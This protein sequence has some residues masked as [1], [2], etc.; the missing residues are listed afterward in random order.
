MSPDIQ[1][2]AAEGLQ[3]QLAEALAHHQAGRLHQAETLYRQ[4]LASA[5]DHLEA[6]YLLAILAQQ[7]GQPAAALDLLD[8]AIRIQ[9]QTAELHLRRG[10]ALRMLGQHQA[11]VASFDRALALAPNQPGACNNRGLALQSLGQFQDALDAFD[12]ALQLQ[13]DFAEAYVNRSLALHALGQYEQAVVSCDSALRLR[14]DLAPAHTYRGNALHALRRYAEAVASF[15]AATQLQPDSAETHNNCG[16]ALHQ[17][18]RFQPAVAC[19]DRALALQPDLAEAHCNRGNA[20]FELGQYRPALA[21][22]DRAVALQPDLARAHQNRGV[23]LNALGQ[24]AE[25]LTALDHALQLQPRFALAWGSRAATLLGMQQHQAALESC[26]RALTLDPD[27][28]EAYANRG[29]VLFGWQRH[30]AALADFDRALAL[31]PEMP[32][33]RG[34]R[35]QMRR[36]LCDW[37]G[38]EAETRALEASVERGEKAAIPAVFLAAGS[39]PRLQLRAAEICAQDKY[40]APAV[41]RPFPPR[42]PHRPIRIGYYS[43]DFHT[44]AICNLMA[45]VFERHDRTRFQ[46]FAFSFGDTQDEVT[47]RVA[48]AMDQFLD[49]RSLPDSAIANRSRE[50]EI[51]I[52]VDLMGF[53]LN[54]RT[55]IFAHRAAPI[56]VN[57]LGYP[58]TMGTAF[59]DYILADSTLIPTSSRQHYAEKIAYLPDTF[60]ATASTTQASATQASTTLRTRAQEGLPAQGFVFCC[61]NG[62]YK[63]GPATFDQWMRILA[64][65][66]GSVLWL[67]EDNPTAAAN[68]NRQAALRGIA[69]ERLVFAGRVPLADHLAR[70]RLADLFLDTLPFN[71]GATASPALWAG[72]PVLTC[73]GETFAGRMA[74][75][76]LRAIGLPEMIAATPADYESLAVELALNPARLLAIRDKLARNRT[77]TP[78][79]DTAR[80]TRNLEA[81]YTAMVRRHDA[82]AAPDH[83]HVAD[84]IHP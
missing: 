47:Q 2:G 10:D 37:D 41:L 6:L 35:L 61:F 28:A 45:E 52:A 70:Q 62:S 46:L 22:F 60:Q 80:F 30:I 83:I 34:M 71:A 73:M 3:Q 63:I 18:C 19:F 27:C 54:C 7:V 5:P 72:L 58:A 53:T 69:P 13:P 38:V 23:A 81:A 50:L 44:H 39:S 25:A 17:L 36:A 74:A 55:G 84:P 79:F 49:V 29:A 26:D 11:A 48:A 1:P 57:Y 67:L 77:T 66:P 14:P 68:L 9:P 4:V 64:R 65:V 76:L 40:P 16:L 8:Q 82:G 75:S 32:Y 51:D 20:L 56:Q 15:E 78:L 31:R 33:V 12:R 42:L 59:M 24:Y 43:A 21:A